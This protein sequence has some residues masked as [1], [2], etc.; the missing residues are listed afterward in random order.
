VSGYPDGG[1]RQEPAAPSTPGRKWMTGVAALVVVFV[2]LACYDL[3]S[4]G[5]ASAGRPSASRA[6]GDVAPRATA[7]A[8]ARSAT[9][10]STPGAPVIASPA[11]SA[12]SSPSSSAVSASLLT[13][14]SAAAYGPDGTSDGDHANLA[15]GII[16]GGDGQAWYSSWYATP[17]FGNLQSGT[18]VLLDMG[19]TVNL[20]RVQL[21]LAAPVGA[22]VQVRVG[23][24]ALPDEMSVAASASD[25]GGT[26]QLRDTTP[27][28]G[29]YVLIWF[30]QLPL[31]QQGEYQ[32]SVYS[33]TVYGT[34]GTLFVELDASSTK[35]DAI[36]SYSITIQS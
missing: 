36:R 6:A 26:V 27:A 14:A 16:N 32:V 35:L 25:V 18:G 30:T 34:K 29:Q 9:P 19:E 11:D 24:M 4:N 3:V 10:A 17:E 23:D 8:S 20:S 7:A 31:K 12:T 1:P 28:S 5:V 15:P 2:A 22:D 33:A 21:V 13:V